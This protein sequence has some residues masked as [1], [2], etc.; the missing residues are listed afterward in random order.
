M[1]ARREAR[2]HCADELRITKCNLSWC[3]GRV[4]PGLSNV[5][6]CMFRLYRN[7]TERLG[8]QLVGGEY[9]FGALDL[10]LKEI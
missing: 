3:F 7:R 1:I 9:L 8:Y 10:H 2:P 4:H 6:N 5:F